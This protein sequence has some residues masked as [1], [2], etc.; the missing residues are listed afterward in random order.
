MPSDRSAKVVAFRRSGMWGA[1]TH[2]FKTS[3]VELIV[4]NNPLVSHLAPPSGLPGFNPSKCLADAKRRGMKIICVDPRRSELARQADIHLQLRPGEDATLLA[5]MLNVILSEGL[6]DHGFC[7]KHVAGL[8]TLAA[9]VSD[10]SLDYVAER[11]QL[12]GERIARAARLFAAGP[13][14]CATSGTGPDMAPH[15]ALSEHLLMAM[16]LA[17]GRVNREGEAIDNPGVLGAAVPRPAQAI[18]GL[19]LPP[20]FHLNTGVRARVRDLERVCD[21]MPSTTLSDEILMPGD[22]QI[23]ALLCLGGNPAMSVPDQAKIAKALADLDL[24]VCA[25]LEITATAELADYVIAARHPLEREDVTLFSDMF[26]EAPYSHYTPALLAPNGETIDDWELVTG[27]AARMGLDL[28]LPGGT[29]TAGAKTDKFG[30]LERVVAGSRVPLGVIRD[31]NGGGVFSDAEI[32]ADA[33]IE[34][35]EMRLEFT[36]TGIVEELHQLREEEAAA[37]D[38]FPFLLVCRRMPE[39]LNSV[40]RRFPLSRERAPTNPAYMHPQDLEVIGVTTGEPVEIRSAQGSI[41]ATAQASEDLKPGVVSIAHCWGGLPG[42]SGDSAGAGVS[43]NLLVADDSEIDPVTGMARQTAVPV[44]IRR[45][46]V[47]HGLPPTE[48]F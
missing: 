44:A 14:G 48:A 22:G 13:R 47:N 42:E 24:L 1:W 34:G 4:G 12:D 36:P 39:V 19:M 21:E 2:S 11:T 3:D 23:R 27:L 18:P 35:I 40:G 33:A 17:C 6:H 5:G 43:T 38:E 30:V 7:D 41:N 46:V 45:I 25:E 28:P 16:N 37:N 20:M 9:A 10:F 29:I 15:P 8:D 31:R 26:Y 32:R